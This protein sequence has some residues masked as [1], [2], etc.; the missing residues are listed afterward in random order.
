MGFSETEIVL[1]GLSAPADICYSPTNDII[2]I[3]NSGNNSITF[4]NTSCNNSTLIEIIETRK[5][6]KT[7]N[8]LGKRNSKELFQI[9]NI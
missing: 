8:V 2:G 6:I 4:A 3:P 7:I 1:N 5:V 9:R